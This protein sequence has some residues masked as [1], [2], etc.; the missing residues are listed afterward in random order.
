MYFVSL[1]L[2]ISLI[3]N[4]MLGSKYS[5]YSKFI[6]YNRVLM[7]SHVRT[8]T[9]KSILVL[10]DREQ[11]RPKVAFCDN[12]V[13]SLEHRLNMV[14]VSLFYRYIDGKC[15]AEFKE[16]IP[17]THNFFV[18]HASQQELIRAVRMWKYFLLPNVLQ[19]YPSPDCWSMKQ[20]DVL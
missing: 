5:S 3:V 7:N 17:N 15:S 12:S 8:V 14:C 10:L 19:S 6:F 18:M 13:N 20:I 1:F 16:L 11:K 4:R 2:F 9:L